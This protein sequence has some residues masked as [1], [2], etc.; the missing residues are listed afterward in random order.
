M[1]IYPPRPL[2]LDDRR[3]AGLS[4]VGRLE[5][6]CGMMDGVRP[7]CQIRLIDPRTRC[8]FHVQ[9]SR[10]P[11]LPHRM[12][13]QRLGYSENYWTPSGSCVHLIAS[14]TYEHEIPA[15]VSWA[16]MREGECTLARNT[17]ESRYSSRSTVPI[18]GATVTYRIRTCITSNSDSQSNVLDRSAYRHSQTWNGGFEAGAVREHKEQLTGGNAKVT[19]QDD[20]G[21][22]RPGLQGSFLCPSVITLIMDHFWLAYTFQLNPPLGTAKTDV[23]LHLGNLMDVQERHVTNRI[24]VCRDSGVHGQFYRSSLLWEMTVGVGG[25]CSLTSEVVA[26]L[27]KGM[28]P[29]AY[30]DWRGWFRAGLPFF[31]GDMTEMR[32]PLLPNLTHPEYPVTSEAAQRFLQD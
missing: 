6:G 5:G 1:L 17:K 25:I 20:S 3:D 4:P 27:T 22:P 19:M 14:C 24:P 11:P 7:H 13:R 8:A 28:P 31:Q 12:R 26:N 32:R 10:P 18:K 9:I 16:S 30:F 23:S 2:R 21:T 29:L 15:G